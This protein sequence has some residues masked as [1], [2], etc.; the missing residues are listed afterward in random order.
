MIG[1][2]PLDTEKY[3]DKEWINR[4]LASHRGLEK[5]FPRSGLFTR[6]QLDQIRDF[7]VPLV[8]KPVRGR[9]SHGVTM[10]ETEE[11]ALSIAK[12]LLEESDAVLVEVSKKRPSPT[13]FSTLLFP[14]V[15]SKH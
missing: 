12:K 9:G 8:I 1:Q 6:K 7:G 14:D 5:A 11:D 13:S 3:E 4:W 2:S 15:E 10:V